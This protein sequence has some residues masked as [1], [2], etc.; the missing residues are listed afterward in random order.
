MVSELVDF[1]RTIYNTEKDIPLHSPTFSELE[2]ELVLGC[3]EDTFVSSV[4]EKVNQ[5]EESLCEFTGSKFAIATNSGTSALHLA[6]IVAG[7][8]KDDLVLTQSL[9]FVATCN[10]LAYVGA[11]PIFVDVEPEHLGVCTAKLQNFLQKNTYLNKYGE[12]VENSSGRIIRAIMPM[13]TFGHPANMQQLQNIAELWNLSIVEDAAEGLG[14]QYNGKS[15]GTFGKVSAL[16]FNGNKIITTGGGGAL[17]TDNAEIAKQARHLSSTAKI[18]NGYEFEHNEIGYNYRMPNLNA[19]LGLGQ[20]GSLPRFLELKRKLSMQYKAFFAA[21][22]FRFI[23]EPIAAQSNFWLNAVVCPN[24]NSREQLLQTLNQ[25]HIHARPVWKPMHSLPMFD[26]CMSTD[27]SVTN[28]LA[29]TL[30]NLP[31]SPVEGI[32]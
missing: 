6:L 26:T 7:V 15:L 1:I 14:S 5:F 23:D 22:N 28:S 29:E 16:S 9:T 11:A 18:S 31:S 4:G 27:L 8:R 32:K 13:H 19:A 30:L 2:K 21:S 24:K 3:I 25:N 12:C 17:L 20:L 10:A